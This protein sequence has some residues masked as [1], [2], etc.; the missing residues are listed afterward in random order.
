MRLTMAQITRDKEII[1][2]LAKQVAADKV[3]MVDISSKIEKQSVSVCSDKSATTQ[4]R[5]TVLDAQAKM[6]QLATTIAEETSQFLVMKKES[7][8]RLREQSETISVNIVRVEAHLTTTTQGLITE[9]ANTL[10]KLELGNEKGDK[11]IRSIVALNGM[12]HHM[13]KRLKDYGTKIQTKI[14]FEFD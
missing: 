4:I 6:E 11:I 8:T 1:T 13:K 3:S 9:S 10:A 5:T 12:E 7:E 14:E 2:N